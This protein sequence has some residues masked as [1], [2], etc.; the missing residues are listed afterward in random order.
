MKT[1]KRVNPS[2]MLHKILKAGLALAALQSTVA[3]CTTAAT[4]PDATSYGSHAEVSAFIDEMASR[5]QFSA[6]ELTRLFSKAQRRDDI[7][8]LMRKPAES[9]PWHRYRPIFLTQ[10]R[11]NGGAAFWEKHADILARA[12][13]E[14][15]VDAQIIVAIIGVETRYGS[16][17]GSHR[18]LDAL[19]TLAFDYPPRS[20]FF[21][22]ELEHYL[23]LGRE[24]GIDLLETRGSYAGAMGY[25]QFIPSSYRRY[26][27]DFDQDGKRDLWGSPMDIIG[28]VANYLHE[29]GWRLDAP[30][31]TRATVEGSGYRD[32]LKLGV[33]PVTRLGELGKVGIRPESALPDEALGALIELEDKDGPAYWIGLNNFY[34]ITR[35][36]RSPLYAMAVYQLS[37]EIRQAYEQSQ[38][39][40]HD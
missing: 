23:V 7:L 4:A 33:K 18:V 40:M 22:S 32:I 31:T 12:E 28:S 21:R 13:Q 20:T 8:A 19:A 30:I 6:D 35:Y 5:H 29:H 38:K 10:G 14:Y 27:V 17:T 11:I 3:G 26:A 9:L 39:A 34:V 36:N 16:N 24:E 1:T 37:E 2:F 15:G 25:G